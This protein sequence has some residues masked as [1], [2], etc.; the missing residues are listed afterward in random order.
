MD[1][2][3]ISPSKNLLSWLRNMKVVAVMETPGFWSHHTSKAS[4]IFWVVVFSGCPFSYL[5]GFFFSF[6]FPCQNISQGEILK[7]FSQK[8]STTPTQGNFRLF[9][10]GLYTHTLSPSPP[11]S[12][13]YRE[14]HP[15]PASNPREDFA[16][17]PE[18]LRSLLSFPI[19]EEGLIF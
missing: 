1:R 11:S 9:L 17:V 10:R 2:E 14:N 12:R 18:L 5:E 19:K 16:Q 13:K 7:S 15:G 6:F 4:H 3:G 8:H